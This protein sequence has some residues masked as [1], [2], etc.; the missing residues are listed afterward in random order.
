MKWFKGLT[1]KTLK[2]ILN[3]EVDAHYREYQNEYA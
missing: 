2:N 1:I 3:F